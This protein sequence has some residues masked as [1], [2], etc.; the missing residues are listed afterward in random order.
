M[1][2]LDEV[3]NRRSWR[4]GGAV[5]AAALLLGSFG[6]TAA[7]NTRD[8]GGTGGGLAGQG[9]AGGHA[10]GG[11]KDG[12]VHSDA[13]PSGD[14]PL[15]AQDAAVTT[16]EP[17]SHNCAGMGC[18]SDD[19]TAH[20]ASSC[21]ACLS[22]D[23]GVPA[24]SGDGG[25]CD[26]TCAGSLKKCAGRCVA[27]CCIDSDCPAQN[28]KAGQCDTSTY[29]CSYQNC[30][31]GNKVCGTACIPTSNCCVS[32]D[33][34]TACSICTAGSCVPVTNADDPVTGRCAGTCD[35]T[36][37]CKSKRGQPCN[38]VAGLCLG[39]LFCSPDNYCCDRVCT[40]P[41]E[42]C[43][44]VA[45]AG[46]CTTVAD[47]PHVGHTGCQGSNATCS[48]SC[49]AS[50]NGQCVWPTGSCGQSTCANQSGNTATSYVA[51]GTCSVGACGAGGSSSCGGGLLCASTTAC[52]TSCVADTDCITGDYC[53]GGSCATKGGSGA[54]C[55]GNTQCGSGACVDGVCCES[56]CAGLCMACS[57]AKTGN[58]DGLCRGIK[59]GTD[60][61]SE[62]AVDG[63]NA[64]GQDG[65][66]DGSGSCRLQQNGNLLWKLLLH[67]RQLHGR[68]PLQ[69]DG[70]LHSCQR[71]DR[72]PG[73]L[74]LRVDRLRDHLQRGEHR[75]LRLR[76]RVPE[77]RLRPGHR[78]LRWSGLRRRQ[79][80]RI[81]LR[82]RSQ[83]HRN[84]RGAE[85]PPR[86]Q[87]LQRRRHHL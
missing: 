8:D 80:R 58:T 3:L 13:K 27:G 73:Q 64:C 28:G 47:G 83:Q 66:C 6:C 18:V 42:A 68:R 16:C 61:D 70:D 49:S 35:S 86:R 54:T 4:S 33:C 51:A 15:L 19:S 5:F 46:T 29:T 76:L 77:R 36:G 10:T 17:G 14:G 44:V 2:A 55:S 85:L 81:V 9:G 60:P 41:C 38:T 32:S 12:G 26:F 79:R 34:K 84:E 1:R 43:D 71:L 11:N 25:T 39:G 74:R 62:C 69:R 22:P 65:T 72:L 52:K 7:R 50:V 40:G 45:S 48:G 24:C 87:H 53:A 67:Q 57:S 21:S 56:A 23:G 20:C 30:A 78:P 75:W 37:A 82:H 59:A 63:T 31:A